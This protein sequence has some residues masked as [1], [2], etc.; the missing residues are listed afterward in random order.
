M[1]YIIA[2]AALL[3]TGAAIG[4]TPQVV[5][6]QNGN[7]LEGEVDHLGQFYRVATGTSEIRLPARNVERIV[8]TLQDAYL[9]KRSEVREGSISDHLALASWCIRQELWGQTDIELDAARK[10]DADNPNI[11]FIARRLDVASRAALRAA[12]P[13]AAAPAPEPVDTQR[14]AAELAELEQ[15]AANL[16]PGS[17]E[18]F[19]RHIQPILVNGCAAGGCH[20]AGDD[21]GLKLNRDL[22]RGLANRESTLRNL[23]AV[24]ES[25][26]QQTPD[27]SPL[28]L[29]PAVPHGGLPQPVFS[30]HRQKVQQKLVDWVRT[31]TGRQHQ[32]APTNHVELAAHQT[33]MTPGTPMTGH[34][35]AERS[36]TESQ[37][38]R[39][40]WEDP[41]AGA[42]PMV[43][44]APM[45]PTMKYG[46]TP[47]K[48][49]PR[50][51]FDPELFNRQ[52]ASPKETAAPQNI[53]PRSATE[54]A[55]PSE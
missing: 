48:F 28:L 13:V 55:A 35:A 29:Q 38:P 54:H 9:A 4:Q 40:F 27:Y 31:A 41:E 47:K 32:P 53:P 14:R 22:V 23:K 16:P 26:D 50:D 2:L 12:Q 10:I 42:P 1:K 7:V 19:A 52:H 20:S 34:P 30:G 17:L 33:S 8:A 49:K 15:L 37:G 6:L 51:E 45:Q 24:W 11:A 39:H 25:I 3:A 18:E 5:V 43:E 36:P 46:A 21:N 44:G